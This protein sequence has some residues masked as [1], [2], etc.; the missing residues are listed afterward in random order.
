MW[1]WSGI[2]LEV[3]GLAVV[4]Y[5]RNMGVWMGAEVV[6]IPDKQKPVKYKL[7]KQHTIILFVRPCHFHVSY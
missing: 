6:P 3:V 2:R 5:R 1:E 7:V 4:P